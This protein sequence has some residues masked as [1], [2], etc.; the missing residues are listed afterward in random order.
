MAPEPERVHRLSETER[1]QICRRAEAI[2][3]RFLKDRDY[4][5]LA[6]SFDSLRS[7]DPDGTQHLTRWQADAALL[8]EKW[9]AAWEFRRLGLIESN[10]R[11]TIEDI[12]NVR[13]RCTERSLSPHDLH[14]FLLSNNGLTQWGCDHLSQINSALGRYLN[15]LH[16][17]KR[18]NPLQEFYD[19]YAGRDLSDDDFAEVAEACDYSVSP[20][21]L[22]RHIEGE[23]SAIT[24]F[25]RQ[26]TSLVDHQMYEWYT[27]PKMWCFQP[28]QGRY[29]EALAV[30]HRADGEVVRRDHPRFPYTR[31]SS[32]IRV[33]AKAVCQTLLRRFEN[34]ARRGAGLPE[35]GEG[36]L[37]ET[38]L[39]RSIASTFFDTPVIQHARPQWLAPQHLDIFLPDYNVAVEYHG[40]QHFEAIDFF[41]GEEG[42][43]RRRKQDARK[44]RLCHKN[45]CTLIEVTAGYELSHVVEQVS[46]AVNAHRSNL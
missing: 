33:A 9:G 36:W 34:D 42:L 8:A 11:I 39:Y 1:C 29:V 41:G 12:I 21:L 3:H 44:R 26:G 37:S 23:N 40:R 31:V 14:L 16:R 32:W 38:E 43:D 7:E 45:G 17:E 20:E 25:R 18:T 28:V 13:A 30:G 22:R 19:R 5:E 2:I 24:H 6:V 4:R 15:D 46:S 27:A 35:I 10:R